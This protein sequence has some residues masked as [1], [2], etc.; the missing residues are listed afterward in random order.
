MSNLH[1]EYVITPSSNIS[2]D[3]IDTDLEIL[4]AF[5]EDNTKIVSNNLIESFFA[6]S[7]GEKKSKEKT[8]L[9]RLKELG[10]LGAIKNSK[11]TSE[12]YKEHLQD[13]FDEKL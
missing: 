9:Q 4:T 3:P 13:Y 6:Y 10:L 2:H 7:K 1:R 12:N 8:K 11:I 5:F